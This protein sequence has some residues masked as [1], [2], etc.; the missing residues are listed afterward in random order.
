MTN[1]CRMSKSKGQVSPE[2]ECLLEGVISVIG[3]LKPGFM[4]WVFGL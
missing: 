1:K 4:I 3:K 2:C